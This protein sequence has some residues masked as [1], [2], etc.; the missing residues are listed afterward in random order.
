MRIPGLYKADTSASRPHQSLV[1]SDQLM[2][3]GVDTY[4]EIEITIGHI[5][6]LL[7]SNH[8]DV[9]RRQ[10]RKGHADYFR[11]Q[12]PTATLRAMVRRLFLC[13]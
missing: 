7:I 3:S 13:T 10:V 8:E 11:Y 1:P 5:Q 9:L 2:V 12:F 4:K 6:Y